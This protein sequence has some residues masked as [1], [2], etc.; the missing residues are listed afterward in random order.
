MTV[1]TMAARKVRPTFLESKPH[2]AWSRSGIATSPAAN[3]KL[4]NGVKQ[5][6]VHQ[7]KSE[8]T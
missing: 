7:Q 5:S 8:L 6:V 3:M 2:M 1:G 4:D